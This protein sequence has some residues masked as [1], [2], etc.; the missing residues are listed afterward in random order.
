MYDQ[1]L[2]ERLLSP[3][4]RMVVLVGEP[5][6]RLEEELNR[7]CHAP[8]FSAVIPMVSKTAQ[9]EHYVETSRT[10]ERDS[11]NCVMCLH[12]SND[13]AD[14]EATLGLACRT[15]PRLLLVEQSSAHSSD[16]SLADEHFFAFG[17]RV[18]EKCQ[19]AGLHKNLYAY[20]L[21]DY[22]QAPEWLNARFWA[23]PERFDL[24]E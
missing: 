13:A 10:V 5:V 1:R 8:D 22:K 9:V 4:P 23:H 11:T 17:F 21:R 6:F 19:D 16:F 3:L 24:P 7:Q 12:L 2:A 18:V 14:P 15:S 20:S